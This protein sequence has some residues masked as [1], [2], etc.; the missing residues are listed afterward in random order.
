LDVRLDPQAAMGQPGAGTVH[1]IAFRT[2]DADTQLSWRDTLRK[3]G[4]NV[5]EVRDR[6]YFRSIYFNSPGGVLFEIATDRPGFTVDEASAELGNALKLPA[7]YE[8]MRAEIEKRLPGLRATVFQHVFKEAPRD[9]DD[10][11]TL[12]ALHGTGGDERDLLGFAEAACG[13]A[14]ILSPRGKVLENG[15]ARYFERRTSGRFEPS[16]V[17]RRAHE[18]SD[19]ISE[20]TLK[21]NRDPERL[22]AIGYSNGANIAAAILLLKPE[23]FSGAVLMRPMLP[24]QAAPAPDLR[25]KEVLVLKGARDRVIASADT[26]RLVEILEKA[27]AQVTLRVTPGGHELTAQDLRAA[28]IWLQ[29]R[30]FADQCVL[31]EEPAMQRA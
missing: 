1:H 5:T 11:R 16:E 20:A 17:A 6:K 10:G 21:H 23:I 24:L 9:A 14:A 12:V 26:D 28:L 15:L 19:F 22:T 8:P 27:G 7:A 2:P 18:L 31:E 3:S 29:A 30:Q 13:T 4:V 25:G